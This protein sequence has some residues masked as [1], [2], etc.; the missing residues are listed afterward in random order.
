MVTWRIGLTCMP[1][2][3]LERSLVSLLNNGLRGFKESYSVELFD[4][5]GKTEYFDEIKKKFPMVTV[6]CDGKSRTVLGNNLRMWQ[7]LHENAMWIMVFP[8][9]FVTCLDLLQF[10]SRFVNRYKDLFDVFSFWT[11]F[12]HICEQWKKH[13]PFW[14]W[15][16]QDFYGGIGLTMKAKVA[17][18]C[19]EWV[20]KNMCSLPQF[21]KQKEWDIVLNTFFQKPYRTIC[22]AVPNL[23]QHIGQVS[24]IGNAWNNRVA[25]CFIGEDKSP[26]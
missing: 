3:Y 14:R 21:N 15:L 23:T 17:R 5:S 13:Q 11:P 8:D 1:R 7:T 20:I 12:Q 6:H 16:P 10:A 4:G 2:P 19:V 9:D 24:S 26:L 22:A 18:Q 25:P